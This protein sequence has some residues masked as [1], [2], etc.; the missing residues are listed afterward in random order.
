MKKETLFDAIDAIDSK[1]VEDTL[2]LEEKLRAEIRRQRRIRISWLSAIAACLCLVIVVNPIA[3]WIRA[4]IGKGNVGEL[5]IPISP[6]FL[7]SVPTANVYTDSSEAPQKTLKWYGQSL[8]LNYVN[9]YDSWYT[10]SDFSTYEIEGKENESITFVKGTDRIHKISTSVN[11]SS[12]GVFTEES[13]KAKA[14]EIVEN[15]STID[16]DQMSYSCISNMT[17]ESEEET[18]DFFVDSNS[19]ESYT[20]EYVQKTSIGYTNCYAKVDFGVDGRIEVELFNEDTAIINKYSDMLTKSEVYDAIESAVDEYRK[21]NP[22]VEGITCSVDER[23]TIISTNNR[24]Y[25]V[26]RVKLFNDSDSEEYILRVMLMEVD[27]S[28]YSG[29]ASISG[30]ESLTLDEMLALIDEMEKIYRNSATLKL[31]YLD[32]FYYYFKECLET[33]EQNAVVP[34]DQLKDEIVPRTNMTYRDLKAIISAGIVYDTDP[35]FQKGDFSGVGMTQ[36]LMN[37]E[38]VITAMLI[39]RLYGMLPAG[40][41]SFRTEYDIYAKTECY[42]K[43]VLDDDE[44]KNCTLEIA[45][46]LN[47]EGETE[48]TSILYKVSGTEYT[49]DKY[50]TPFEDVRSQIKG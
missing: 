43:I 7:I 23:I 16:I 28:Y 25:A 12:R 18:V 40:R 19:V 4:M 47:F 33:F 29:S 9:S 8:T 46:V 21:A 10:D 35:K 27:P 17:E 22:K 1:I 49:Y 11:L 45:F 20:I 30:V 32:F 26:T 42:V 3:N 2:A 6:E 38:A 36:Y 15:Y 5:P 50:L 44:A 39:D 41:V 37:Y 34:L 13:L 14:K 24:L 48:I 31:E